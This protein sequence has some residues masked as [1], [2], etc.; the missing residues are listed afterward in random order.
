MLKKAQSFLDYA[1]LI[2]IVSISLAT[3]SGYIIRSINAR[4]YHIKA[5]LSDPMNGVR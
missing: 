4:F 2:A 5:D 1:L 3:M